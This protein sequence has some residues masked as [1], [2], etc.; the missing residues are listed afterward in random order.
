MDTILALAA[1]TATTTT[2]DIV[3][4]TER[5]VTFLLNVTVVPGVETLTAKI[6]GKDNLGNYYDIVVGTASAA[7]GI[8]LLKAGLG[9][10]SVANV[11]IGDMLPDLYRVV[12]THSAAGSFTYSLT[13]NIAQ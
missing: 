4:T 9:I 7:T 1:R 3:K 10:A 12:I 8:V 6:Q 5:A 11:A 2:S 13:R